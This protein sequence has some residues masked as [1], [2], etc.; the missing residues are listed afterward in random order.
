MIKPKF[1]KYLFVFIV[2]FYCLVLSQFGFENFDTGYI[3]SFSWRIINGENVYEDF[4]YKGPPATLYFHALIMK[5]LP[6]TGQ[7][8]LIRAINYFLFSLQVY[9]TVSG[10]YNLY[11]LKKSSINKWAVMS[12]CFIVSLLNFSPYPWPTTDGLLFAAVAFWLVSRNEN[13]N[14]WKLLLIAFFT[15]LSALTKQSF[16]L[17]PFVFL[18][19]IYFRYTLKKAIYFTIALSILVALYV[20]WIVSITTLKNYIQQTTGET[21]LHQLY[22]SGFYNYVPIPLHLIPYVVISGI[23]VVIAYLFYNKQKNEIIALSF[24][25]ISIVLLLVSILLI[26]MHEAHLASRIA[27]D[28]AVLGLAYLF[29]EQ[30]KTIQFYAPILVSLAIAWSCSISLGYDYPILYSTGIILSLII[31]LEDKLKIA[32]KYYFWIALPI[33]ISAFSYNLRPYRE[34]NIFELNSSL[35]E[36]SPKLKFIKTNKE[37]LEKY[38][39]LKHLVKK[40]GENFIVAPNISMANYL[41]NDQSELPADWIINTEVNRKNDLFIQ[42]ASNKKNYVFLEKS[43]LNKEE[44]MPAQIEEFSYISWFIYTHFNQI[45]ETKHFIVYNSL[46]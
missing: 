24:K 4:F 39:E 35:E 44:Y 43:F 9:L 15:I 17:I 34:K 11:D 27:F 23:V 32:P 37:S 33:S 8:F 7:F 31:I 25:W 16:Y 29:F 6:E 46:K 10:F 18:I 12:L 21:A 36:V 20:C 28:A 41:F 14:F 19:W 3:P 22:G 42:L 40:Y 5:I 38:L 26:L 13:L 1:Y 2:A 30:K 45:E